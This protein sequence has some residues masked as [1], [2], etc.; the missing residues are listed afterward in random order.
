MKSEDIRGKTDHELG[1]ELEKMKKE[2]FD[3][4]F[5]SAT[6]AV[7]STARIRTVRRTIARVH[8]ILNER[9]LGVRGQKTG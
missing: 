9:A 2:L 1:H 8:T 3:L 4:R 6:Q 5:K 7:P